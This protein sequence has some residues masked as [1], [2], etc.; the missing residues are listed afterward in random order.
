MY[1]LYTSTPSN[2]VNA[3]NKEVTFTESDFSNN[4]IMEKKKKK[5]NELTPNVCNCALSNNNEKNRII[6]MVTIFFE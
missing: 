6:K 4:V 5:N 3:A 2:T 1:C